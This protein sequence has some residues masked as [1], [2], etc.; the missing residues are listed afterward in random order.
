MLALYFDESGN[1]GTNYLDVRQPYF[2]YGGWLIE[3]EKED[4]ILSL[5]H[6]SEPT[7]P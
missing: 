4:E 5:I 1:T 7:R 3:K 2:V 6:I